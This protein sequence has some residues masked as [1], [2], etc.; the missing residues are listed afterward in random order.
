MRYLVQDDSALVGRFQG[1][2]HHLHIAD[3]FKSVVPAAIGEVDEMG[4]EIA[5]D[6]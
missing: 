3:A 2:T 1:H 5:L 6:F 4:N